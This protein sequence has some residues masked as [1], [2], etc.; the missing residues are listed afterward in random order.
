MLSTKEQIKQLEADYDKT[1]DEIE[2]KHQG[3]DYHGRLP[4][5]R[6]KIE[7]AKK[8]SRAF[9]Q[10]HQAVD[11]AVPAHESRHLKNKVNAIIEHVLNEEHEDE[12][13]ADIAADFVED[14][15]GRLDWMGNWNLIRSRENPVQRI[16][17]YLDTYGISADA[18]QIAAYLDKLV[19]SNPGRWK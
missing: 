15:L 3:V 12:N 5:L 17:S 13:L 18:T 19:A 2:S 16:Q 4:A 11:Q 7:K 1:F 14:E 10:V 6:A 9:D 8:W